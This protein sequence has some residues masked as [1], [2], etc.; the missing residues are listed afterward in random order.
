MTEANPNAPGHPGRP[1]RWTSS[2]KSGI[3]TAVSPQ[4]RVWFTIS[5]GIIDEVYYPNLDQAT[6][7]DLGFLVA[8]GSNFF[9][10]EKRDCKH[11]IAQVHKDV[12]GYRLNSTCK[13][14]RYG[15]TKTVITDPGRNVLLQR[16][17]FEPLKGK[18]IDYG[19]YALLAPHID[20]RGYGNNGWVGTYKGIPM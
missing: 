12:P 11:K 19:M 13:R 9:S 17:R 8:D 1:P 14:S 16:V 7:R 18:L 5:H 10:E 4:S 3:G 6:T 15:I 20:N 2:A